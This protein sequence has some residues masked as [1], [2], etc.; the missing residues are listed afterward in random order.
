[1]GAGRL[2]C[3]KREFEFIVVQS[4][5]G[6]G[7]VGDRGTAPTPARSQQRQMA[8]GEWLELVA[9]PEGVGFGLESVG[10]ISVIIVVERNVEAQRGAIQRIQQQRL[11]Y[12][13]LDLIA[14]CRLRGRGEPGAR[15]PEVG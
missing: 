5:V 11:L 14:T 8:I 13:E 2:G 3:G 4:Y 15:W 1:M 10:N 9:A 12:D 6:D 7:N